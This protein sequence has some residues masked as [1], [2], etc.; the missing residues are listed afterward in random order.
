MQ[1]QSG[2]L[3]IDQYYMNFI[4]SLAKIPGGLFAAIFLKRFSTRPVFLASAVLI[5]A[6]HLTM[7]LTNMAVLP[8]GFALVAIATIQF[9]S[10]GGYISVSYLLLGVL[11]PSRGSIQCTLKTSLKPSRITESR[12]TE[13][14]FENEIQTTHPVTVTHSDYFSQKIIFLY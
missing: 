1:N 14:Q 3:G 6:A 2:D 4:V 10:S 5:A 12:I 7:G 13:V 9:A 8:S 11:L